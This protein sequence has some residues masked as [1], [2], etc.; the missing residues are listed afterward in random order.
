M[1]I[2][3]I[4][5]KVYS[6]RRVETNRPS[7]CQVLKDLFTGKAEEPIV[8]SRISM[9]RLDDQKRQI[10]IG[11]EDEMMNEENG[12]DCLERQNIDPNN[13]MMHRDEGKKVSEGLSYPTTI[14]G[15]HK[16]IGNDVFWGDDDGRLREYPASLTGLSLDPPVS[17][18]STD[19]YAA[20]SSIR[21]S[22]NVSSY[23]A[24][25]EANMRYTA[26]K[27]EYFS[28]KNDSACN[29]DFNADAS[30]GNA[31]EDTK[32]KESNDRPRQYYRTDFM[33]N[34]SDR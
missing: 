17:D 31:S 2:I 11:F 14:S 19:L 1:Q 9:I 6:S 20:A 32:K 13:K 24:D 16:S 21:L 4:A 8:F 29:G 28:E 15:G 12:I 7:T 3:F 33:M 22:S 10:E 26:G 5:L 25:P 30:N 27:T 23:R 34:S 18:T